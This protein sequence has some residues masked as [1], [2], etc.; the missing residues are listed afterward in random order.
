MDASRKTVTKATTIKVTTNGQPLSW[1]HTTSWTI[2][3]S[4]WNA[5]KHQTLYHRHL[6]KCLKC[7]IISYKSETQLMIEISLV[8]RHP[9]IEMMMIIVSKD[10]RKR[11]NMH[12]KM[13]K[14]PRRLKQTVKVETLVLHVT[15]VEGRVVQ[16]QNIL[17]P[18]RWMKH[19]SNLVVRQV[20][21]QKRNRSDTTSH[22]YHD[23]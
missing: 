13:Q 16:H 9:W 19:H 23:W 4:T 2:T 15:N 22:R 12:K 6:W 10:M 18:S 7:N 11:P 21:T 1:K 8:T 17:I 3:N 14:Q 20:P 5:T